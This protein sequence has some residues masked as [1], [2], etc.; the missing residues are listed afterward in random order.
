MLGFQKEREGAQI[1]R[2]AGSAAGEAAFD[3]L[4]G[5]GA[6]FIPSRVGRQQVLFSLALRFRAERRR[7]IKYRNKT[8]QL[9]SDPG[10]SDAAANRN[11]AAAVPFKFGCRSVRVNSLNWPISGSDP[12]NPLGQ[13]HHTASRVSSEL[14]TGLGVHS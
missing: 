2:L 5:W 7:K 3:A 8:S 12:I 1:T 4:G 11:S 9:S 14:T 13:P 6:V 10:R